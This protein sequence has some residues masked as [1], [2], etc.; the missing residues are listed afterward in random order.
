MST[1]DDSGPTHPLNVGYLVVG[2]V[3]LGIAGLWALHAADVVDT[4]QVGWLL[5]LTLLVAGI[6]GLVALAARG[7]TRHPAPED[8]TYDPYER[9]YDGSYDGSYE[10]EDHVTDLATLQAS[11]HRYPTGDEHETTA[12]L[13]RHDADAGTA[14]ETASESTSETT[15]ETTDETTVRLDPDEGGAR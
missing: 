12:V 1:R 4:A 9:P 15:S 3:C 5:P 8:E 7:V 11:A 10:E 13:S 2:L 14:D 6:I